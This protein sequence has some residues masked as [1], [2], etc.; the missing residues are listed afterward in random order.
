MLSTKILRGSTLSSTKYFVRYYSEKKDFLRGVYP[1]LPTP[2]FPNE[3]VD[4]TSLSNLV[5]FLTQK[6]CVDGITVLGILG[7]AN[8]ITDEERTKII[9]VTIDSANGRPVFVG[10]SHPSSFGAGS[11]STMAEQLGASGVMISPPT[12]LADNPEGILDYYKR[13]S[14]VTS[15]PIILQDHPASTQVKMSTNLIA[16][17]VNT[18]PSVKC[19]KAEGPPTASRI[20]QFRQ[21]IQRKDITILGGLGALYGY[22]ELQSGC[23][24]FMTGFA[25]PEVLQYMYS[26]ATQGKYQKVLESYQ[27]Y[28]PLIVLELQSLAL[29]KEILKRRKLIAHSTVRFPG[30][31]VISSTDDRLLSDILVKLFHSDYSKVVQIK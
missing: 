7:E 18:V 4:Y 8:R 11:L 3:T 26:H 30:S 29:R 14:Q 15:I 31:S 6:V 16:N 5:S 19:I 27:Y 12:E 20:E 25:F 22:F 1:I 10:T 9:K 17:I 23:D 21:K 28:L 13:I 2:F 24:G